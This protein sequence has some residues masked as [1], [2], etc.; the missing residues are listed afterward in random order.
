MSST[1]SPTM[2]LRR[3][4]FERAV[5]RSIQRSVQT[6]AL[7]GATP[8]ALVLARG[9]TDNQAPE[10][11]AVRPRRLRFPED[12]GA[13]PGFRTEWWYLTGWLER[14]DAPPCGVQITFFRA[15]TRH[16]DENPSRFAPTQLL[17]AHA[18]LA[19]PEEGRLL[20]DQRAARGGFG[21]AQAAVHDTKVQIG[22]WNLARTADDHYRAQIRSQIFELALS[23]KA[24]REPVL[25]GN[26]G[27]SAKGPNPQQA[28]FYYS[29]PQLQV[30]GEIQVRSK[31]QT[32]TGRAWLDHE[33]SS[34]LLETGSVGWDWVG[35]NLHDGGSLTAF[36]IRDVHG[37]TRWQNL[38]WRDSQGHQDPL[39]PGSTQSTTEVTFEP[40]R[41]WR[42]TRSGANWPVSMRLRLRDQTSKKERILRL[43]PLLEDQEVDARAS[44]GGYYWEGAV[45]LIDG[46]HSEAPEIGRG[47]LE[48]T[49]YASPVS[50]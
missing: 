3:V 39:Q 14:Q 46:D 9:S 7:I 19:L 5:Q 36:R 43:I 22:P 17:F 1:P 34:T 10:F 21:L 45:R 27:V 35:I 13:H 15:R 31:A 33:W 37:N 29:R 12:H 2:I 4:F 16:P 18:A 8:H 47:Y 11:E 38:A 23:F 26:N 24:A 50:L 41:V 44:T 49:G 6:A 20:H 32:V 42:S 40:L 28:S 25:Q 30:S 48:L